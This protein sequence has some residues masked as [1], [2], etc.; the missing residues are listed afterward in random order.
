VP[1]SELPKPTAQARVDLLASDPQEEADYESLRRM[2]QRLHVP[3]PQAS[4]EILVTGA[5]GALRQR[6]RQRSHSFVRN[7]FNHLI[8]QLAAKNGDGGGVF[9]GGFINIRNTGGSVHKGV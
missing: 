6:L 1:E 2:G 7:A 4:W 5:D 9:G 8:S 3:I